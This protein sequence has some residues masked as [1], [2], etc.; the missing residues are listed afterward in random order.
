MIPLAVK[1]IAP[2]GR[3]ETAPG[4]TEVTGVQV[5]SRRVAP[6][7]LFVAVN[8]AGTGFVADALARGAAA[9]L[10]PEDGFAALAALGGAIRDRS[11]ARIVGITGSAGKTSTKDILDAIC[12]PRART[13]AAEAS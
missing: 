1:E 5:D 12:A 10:V 7:D 8:D 4:A 13:G 3:L 11:R 6:G 9:T 2:L